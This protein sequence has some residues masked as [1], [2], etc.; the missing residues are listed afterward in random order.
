MLPELDISTL[1]IA[2]LV[3]IFSLTVHE[4]AHA[5]SASQLG[6]DTVIDDVVRARAADAGLAAGI[7]YAEGF[8]RLSFS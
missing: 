7:R 6:D 3:L 5:W 2:L 8:R 4:A 1:L